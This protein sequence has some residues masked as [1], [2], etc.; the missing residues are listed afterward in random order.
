[1]PRARPEE[2]RGDKRL[3]KI[4]TPLPK[5][6]DLTTRDYYLA[7]LKDLGYSYTQIADW[8]GLSRRHV[9]RI[10]KKIR[11]RARRRR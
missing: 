11:R 4:P 10:V 9:R 7:G 1:M 2:V 5:F 3:G 8:A 6:A